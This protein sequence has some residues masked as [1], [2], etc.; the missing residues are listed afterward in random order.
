MPDTLNSPEE[1][2]RPTLAELLADC[3]ASALP[4]VEDG[5]WTNGSSVGEELV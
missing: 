5:D 2:R 3:D 4:P 1:P